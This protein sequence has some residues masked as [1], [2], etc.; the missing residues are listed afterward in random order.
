MSEPNF[1]E[2]N[3]SGGS[4]FPSINWISLWQASG[5]D[6]SW[7]VKQ[8]CVSHP[9]SSIK[10]KKS[11][12]QQ[13]VLFIELILTVA[14]LLLARYIESSHLVFVNDP[15]KSNFFESSIIQLETDPQDDS[16]LE[17]N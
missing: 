6:W 13:K 7:M 10:R 17:E 16:F 4:S 12:S 3:S 1:S 14:L 9:R 11:V 5:N 8:N 2:K 15:Q